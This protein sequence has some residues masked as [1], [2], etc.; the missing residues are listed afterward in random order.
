MRFTEQTKH[1]M[2]WYFPSFGYGHAGI[3]LLHVH[4]SAAAPNAVESARSLSAG[5]AFIR[6]AV[7]GTQAQPLLA[8]GVFSGTGGLALCVAGCAEAEPRFAPSLGRLH[9]QFAAQIA[10]LDLPM[11]ER[12]VSDSDYDM[13]S[14]AAGT[15]AY[16][17]SIAEPDQALHTAADKLLDYLIWLSAPPR[18]LTL[19]RRWLIAPELCA[20]L[21]RDPREF[22]GGYLNLGMAHGIPGAVAALAV[23][24]QR[25]LR[26][27]GQEQAIRRMTDWLLAVRRADPHGPVWATEIPVAATGEEV[28]PNHPHDQIAWCYGTAGVAVSLLAVADALGDAALRTAAMAAFEGVLRRSA[29]EPVLSP[30]FCH[31]VAGLLAI[32]LEF[33]TAGS[34]LAREHTPRLLTELLGHADPANPLVFRDEEEPGVFVDSP[35]LL[36]GSTGVAL[37][38]LAAVSPVRPSWLTAFLVR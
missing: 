28:R 17:C 38:L 36:T 24:W 23:A 25:G 2:E 8:P 26:R 35:A 6:E 5:F 21:G 22:P 32:C 3:A 15:L 29:A 16:L 30:T 1:P 9:D 31:G 33:A 14:G 37:T 20:P 7:A 12:A 10:D 13:I 11:V 34:A 27:P 18:D 19:T 4:A